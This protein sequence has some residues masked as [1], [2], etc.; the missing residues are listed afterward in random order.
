MW[1]V[2][3]VMETVADTA[4]FKFN[5]NLV[6]IDFFV[7]HGLIDPESADYLDIVRGLRR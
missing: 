1:P 6:C 7:R 4:D 2:E 5:C 3:R